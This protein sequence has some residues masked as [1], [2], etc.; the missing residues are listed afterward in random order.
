LPLALWLLWDALTFALI[1]RYIYAP[2]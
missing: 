1:P 2:S